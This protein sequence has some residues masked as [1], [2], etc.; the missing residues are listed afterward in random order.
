MPVIRA[1]LPFPEFDDVSIVLLDS[2]L[3]D[4]VELQFHYTDTTTSVYQLY[5][6][7]DD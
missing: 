7:N 4:F 1:I 2:I 3:I 5:S 6:T